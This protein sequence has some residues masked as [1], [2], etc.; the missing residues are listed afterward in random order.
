MFNI[1]IVEDE[2]IELESLNRIVSQC[3]ENAV[4]HEASTGKKA[5]QLI[6]QLNH[7]DM[8][9]VDINIPL[10]NGNQVIEYLRKKNTETKSSSPRRTMISISCAVCITSK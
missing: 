8:I 6:D 3:V 5:I 2:P 4:I 9:F 1:V 7:I 10:P